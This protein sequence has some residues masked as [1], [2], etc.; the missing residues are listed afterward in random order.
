VEAPLHALRSRAEATVRDVHRQGKQK[1]LH[2][3]WYYGKG[4][5]T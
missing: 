5:E 2:R 3:G 1:L 4:L